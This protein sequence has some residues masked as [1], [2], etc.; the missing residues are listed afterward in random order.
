MAETLKMEG[1]LMKNESLIL[2]LICVVLALIFVA[3]VAWTFISAGSVGSFLTIDNLFIT[4]VF[5]LLALV[6]LVNPLMTL[7]ESGKLPIPF[8]HRTAKDSA[9]AASLPPASSAGRIAAPATTAP[10]AIK[11]ASE[12]SAL[13]PARKT[14]RTVP[15]DVEKMLAQMKEPEEKNSQ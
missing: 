7:F 1:G 5:L 11:S 10:G 8:L 15:P 6:F 14:P 4:T 3:L 2:N 9:G 12:R 13:P